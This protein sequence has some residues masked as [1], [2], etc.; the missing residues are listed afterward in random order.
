MPSSASS[1]GFSKQKFERAISKRAYIPN[2]AGFY[3]QVLAYKVDCEFFLIDG[4]YSVFTSQ[5]LGNLF[6]A[7]VI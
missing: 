2:E 7:G 4:T 5:M 1:R 3:M 6:Q